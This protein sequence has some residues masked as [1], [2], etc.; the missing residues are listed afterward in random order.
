MDI[1]TIIL[2]LKTLSANL[3]AEAG[4]ILG[5]QSQIDLAVAQLEGTLVTQN[6]DLDKA[7]AAL[8]DAKK[9]LTDAG[10]AVPDTVLAVAP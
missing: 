3:G 7:N 5:R 8:A 2:D 9:A 4:I 1:Q 6:T 10:L